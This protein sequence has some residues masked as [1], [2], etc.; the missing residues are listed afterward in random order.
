MPSSRSNRLKSHRLLFPA[1]CLY[2][3]IALPLSM[4]TILA[5]WS[6]TPGLAGSHHG[7]EMIFGFA[8]AVI[9]GYTLGPQPARWLFPLFGLWLAARLGYALAPGFWLS[10]LLSPTFALLLAWRVVPRFNAAKKWRNR[11]LVPLMLALCGLPL[12]WLLLGITPLPGATVL[13]HTGVVLLLLLMTFMSGRLIAPAVAGT[14]EKRGITQEA[15]VQPRIEAA[16]IL[17]LG[18]AALAVL[19]PLPSWLSGPLLLA[20]GV[21]ILVRT[22]RWRLWL[23]PERPDLLG[24]AVGTL[25]LGIGAGGFGIALMLNQG[26]SALLHLITV[27]AL[28]TLTIGVMLRL[29]YHATRRQPPPVGLLLITLGAVA[30][31]AL[32]RL[33]AGPSPWD[34]PTLLWAAAGAWSLAYAVTASALL[35]HR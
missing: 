9:A 15:R 30:L 20:A 14:L 10:Q 29:H 23:C 3:A 16:L 1:A 19:L 21:L 2:A 8:L 4:A 35:F 32:P 12:L 22:L 11:M 25:W 34:A 33:A 6:W 17:M 27:G 18:A 5:G 13:L 26:P 28:G 24:L 7:H 31:A